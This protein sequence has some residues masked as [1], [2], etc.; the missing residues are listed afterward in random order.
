MRVMRNFFFDI[1]GTLLPPGKSVPESAVRALYE[2]KEKGCR[3]FFCTGRSMEELPL[4]LYGLPFDGGVFSSGAHVQLGDKVIFHARA[5]EEQRKVFFDAVKKYG[6][7]WVIQ[8][9]DGSYLTQECLDIYN[10]YVMEIHHRTLAFS[11][12]NIVDSFPMEKPIVKMFIIS[13]TGQALEARADMEPI[14]DTVNNVVGIPETV[15][16]E[17]MLP[18]LSKSSGIKRMLEALG[19]NIETSVGIGDGDNDV[20]M[21]EFCNIGIAMGNACASLKAKA[22]FITTDVCEDGIANAIHN[23]LEG[24]WKV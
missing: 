5:T 2:A 21:I 6:L 12:F 20:D 16:S 10:R 1:D 4:E 14:L 3:L 19:D 13:P 8:T 9:E 7:L 18:G 24:D 22:D 17:I 11:G 23:V 15:A